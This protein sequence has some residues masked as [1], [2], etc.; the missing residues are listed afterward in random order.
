MA[1]KPDPVAEPVNLQRL[2]ALLASV[3]RRVLRA[4]AGWASVQA[5]SSD[6]TTWGPAE[7]FSGWLDRHV[8]PQDLDRVFEAVADAFGHRRVLDLTIRT[9]LSISPS[10]QASLH[11]VPFLDDRGQ[12]EEW[13]ATLR[14][15]LSRPLVQE[16]NEAVERHRRMRN[17][18]AL[19]R[20]I[21][22]RSAMEDVGAQSFAMH[23]EGRIDALIGV[24]T[25]LA[26]HSGVGVDL[27]TL[28]RDELLKAVAAESIVH[29]AGVPVFLL[30]PVAE[31]L[32]LAFHELTTNSIKFGALSGAGAGR[33]DVSWVV[34]KSGPTR[35]LVFSWR[36]RSGS[37]ASQTS[38]PEKRSPRRQGFGTELLERML[39]Y[40]LNATAVLEH[41]PDGLVYEVS[42]PL[43]H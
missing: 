8:V 35:R 9:L 26:R 33:I 16:G 23:L 21:A 1:M 20:S 6:G 27:E 5:L 34:E 14:N 18:L 43:R 7:S 32:A 13:W 31:G 36:E 38:R 10:G 2:D 37:G 29:I 17:T 11:A 19:I 24:Q 15:D 30:A 3:D 4:S 25:A 28:L 12:V 40:S 22:R 42:I 41:P 39:A